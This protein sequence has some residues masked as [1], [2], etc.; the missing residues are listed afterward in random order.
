MSAFNPFPS[1]YYITESNTVKLRDVV[2]VSSLCADENCIFVGTKDGKIVCFS[3][4]KL[5]EI[6]QSKRQRACSMVEL[7]EEEL[8]RSSNLDVAKPESVLVGSIEASC[9]GVSLN[10][11]AAAVRSLLH[12]SLPASEEIKPKD[13]TNTR[14]GNIKHFREL[15]LSVGIGHVDF[16]SVGRGIFN[17]VSPRAGSGTEVLVWGHPET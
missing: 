17:V 4:E 1:L 8:S 16:S 11:H 12:I 2:V 10:G 3:V 5:R 13:P 7:Q 6:L 9:S 15:V 14:R